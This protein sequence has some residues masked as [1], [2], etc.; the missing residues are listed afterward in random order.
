MNPGGA[1]PIGIVLED[2]ALDGE[3]RVAITNPAVA[4]RLKVLAAERQKPADKP[5]VNCGFCNTAKK[6]SPNPPDS[7]CNV[8]CH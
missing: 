6:C 2:I 5:N 8:W 3:G 1:A 4:E 7:G